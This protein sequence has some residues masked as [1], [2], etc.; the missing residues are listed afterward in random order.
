MLGINPDEPL[1]VS[2]LEAAK[3][4]GIKIGF[5]VTSESSGSSTTTLIQ[6]LV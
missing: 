2:V 1:V 4:K 5:V 3:L 6:R